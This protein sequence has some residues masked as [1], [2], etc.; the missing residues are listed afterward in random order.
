MC[1]LSH[2][3]GGMCCG[4]EWTKTP[5]VTLFL[6]TW[7]LKTLITHLYLCMIYMHSFT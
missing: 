7:D 6:S 4:T 2:P 1:S 5:D 3:G